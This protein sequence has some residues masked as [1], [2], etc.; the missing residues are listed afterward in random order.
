MHACK[1]PNESSGAVK[2]NAKINANA[3]A[4]PRTRGVPSKHLALFGGFNVPKDAPL[5]AQKNNKT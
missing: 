1:R 5:A 4:S 3:N 2:I